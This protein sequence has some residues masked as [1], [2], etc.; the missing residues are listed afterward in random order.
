MAG[1]E[2]KRPLIW[3]TLTVVEAAKRKQIEVSAFF[4][5]HF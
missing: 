1:S 2:K 4:R 5:T 3:K